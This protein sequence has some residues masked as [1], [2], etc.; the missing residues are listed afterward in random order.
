[1]KRTLRLRGIS[2]EIKGQLWESDTLLRLR[3]GHARAAKER[4]EQHRLRETSRQVCPQ[5]DHLK[6]VW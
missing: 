4:S 1:M 2:G 3:S 6:V 5:Q